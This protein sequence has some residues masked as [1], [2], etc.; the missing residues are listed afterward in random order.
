MTGK[1]FKRY[2]IGIDEVGRGA[3]AGPVVAAAVLISLD[4]EQVISLG[5]NDSKL[6]TVKQRELVNQRLLDMSEIG[7]LDYGIGVIE[8]DKIDNNGIITSTNEAMRIAL[9][10]LN[11]KDKMILV[12]GIINPFED[13]Q[14]KV[15]TII[16]GDSKCYNIGAAS[17]IAK[18]FRDKLMDQL[19]Q[20]EFACYNW[21]RNKGYGTA[22]HIQAIKLYGISQ[23]HRKSFCKNFIYV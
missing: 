13:Q 5:I 21:K 22:E 6:L 17:I 4:E 20:A 1:I 7:L 11:F 18:V 15:E 8:P 2:G 10:H 14:L 16:K 12:D 23:H 9:N 19:S 3:I